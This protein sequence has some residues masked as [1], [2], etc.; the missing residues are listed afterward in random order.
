[1]E[2]L[3]YWLSLVKAEY[4]HVYSLGVPGMLLLPGV[5]R[6]IKYT[7]SPSKDY[8]FHDLQ[9]VAGTQASISLD[10]LTTLFDEYLS[11]LNLLLFCSDAEKSPDDEAVCRLI[12]E[13]QKSKAAEIELKPPQA[14][15]TETF[16]KVFYDALLSCEH[17]PN[18]EEMIQELPLPITEFDA[19]F[20]AIERDY[21]ER[22]W[23]H[24]LQYVPPGAIESFVERMVSCDLPDNFVERM[25]LS[26]LI[27]LHY[28]QT[29]RTSDFGK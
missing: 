23:N 4:K 3:K 1:M 11:S 22:L 5:V 21:H 12:D 25:K 9:L 17:I 14:I 19:A 29:Q 7:I 16:K 27:G 2:T 20:R 26:P 13:V 8:D 10:Y 24:M 28:I 6:P 15:P 18:L